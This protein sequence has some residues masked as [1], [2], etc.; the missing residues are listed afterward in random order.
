MS[1]YLKNKRI[2]ITGATGF[3][4]ANLTKRCI[5]IGTDVYIFSRD[6]SNKWRIKDIL[7]D[8]KNFCVDLLDYENLE[9]FILRIKPEI[10]FHTATYGGYPFQKEE[11]KIIQTNIIGT[12]NLVSACSKVGFDVFVNTGS[13]SEYGIKSNPMNENDILEP[14]NDY[15]VAKASATLFCQ[16]KAKTENLP[17]VTLRL[18]SP[19][20][21]Y[22]EKTRLIPSVIIS[23]LENKIPKLS[24]PKS[25]RD[26][27]FIEDVIDSYFKVVKNKIAGEIFNIGYGKQHSVGEV[28]N[29]IVKLTDSK[30]SPHWETVVNPRIEPK[31]WQADISKAKKILKWEPKYDLEQGLEKT[32][33]WFRKNLILYRSKG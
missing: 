6:T 10:I 8:V 18:F 1:D 17:I 27:V 31:V 12:M 15:G 24:S 26:F 21:Y 11:N 5:E 16:M 23:C 22:E 25:V 28:V 30:I 2:L 29:E 20:G 33:G 4:G 19:Y 14:I 7:K 9:K 3:I 32:I 13:S